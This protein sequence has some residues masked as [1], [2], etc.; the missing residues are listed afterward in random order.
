[1]GFEIPVDLLNMTGGGTDSFERISK[2]HIDY[3]K[4]QVGIN[5]TD[6]ILGKL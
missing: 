4:Y 1:M 6:N 3:L 2:G 5:P